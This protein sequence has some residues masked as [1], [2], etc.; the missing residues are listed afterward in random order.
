MS[1]ST[2]SGSLAFAKRNNV[3]NL[4]VN[5]MRDLNARCVLFVSKNEQDA[6][7]PIIN[8]FR[9]TNETER[10]LNLTNFTVK[11]IQAIC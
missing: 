6:V 10:I 2:N 9:Y 1:F 8:R 3:P 4:S 7:L 11:K 5:D